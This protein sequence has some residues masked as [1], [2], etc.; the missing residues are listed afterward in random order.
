M[1][2]PKVKLSDNTGNAVGVSDVD[3]KNCLDV[4]VHGATIT[5]N[6]NVDS[7]FPAADA[8]T[9][10]FATPET[11]S[12]MAMLM[13]YDGSAWD[14]MRGDSTDGLLVNLGSNNEISITGT[15]AVSMALNQAVDGAIE[16][17][18]TK[19]DDKSAAHDTTPITAM[20]ALKQIMFRLQ[21]IDNGQLAGGHAVTIDNALGDA[22]YIRIADGTNTM[23]TMDT[24]DR[25]GFVQSAQLPADLSNGYLKVNISGGASGGAGAPFKSTDDNFN[26]DAIGI[27]A[28]A[29][30][31][32]DAN[33]SAL[34]D[35]VDGTWTP[36]QTTEDGALIVHLET[37]HGNAGD[38]AT[39]PVRSQSATSGKVTVGAISTEILAAEP[40]RYS[41]TIVNDSDEVIYLKVEDAAVMNEGIR[42]NPNGGSYSEDASI[43]ALYGICASGSKNVTVSTL[44]SGA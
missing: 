23:P 24:A 8:I 26:A 16:T 14:M 11:T 28:M 21:E 1:A 5:G 13:G 42:L 44:F 35:V 33:V 27:A 32:T 38:L 12:A 30:C 39:Y 6:V 7:E 29:V 20:S 3:G 37:I 22:A 9:D 41:Y 43:D 31:S 17:L 40:T 15:V 25:A 36:L 10:N 19:A 2:Y 34:T 4:N 18:G